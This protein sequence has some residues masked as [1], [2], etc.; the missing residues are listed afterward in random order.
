MM[1]LVS[2]RIDSEPDREETDGE[3]P[4]PENLRP[5]WERFTRPMKPVSVMNNLIL[6]K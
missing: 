6:N 2:A 3:M 1:T 4:L 5:V